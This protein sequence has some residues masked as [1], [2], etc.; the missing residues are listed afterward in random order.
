MSERQRAAVRPA[1]KQ[2]TEKG[3][4]QGEGQNEK[5]DCVGHTP[6]GRVF[7]QETIWKARQWSKATHV[8]CVRVSRHRAIRFVHKVNIR[9]AVGGEQRLL[10][11]LLRVVVN[12]RSCLVHNE[13]R[14]VTLVV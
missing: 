12:G 6:R 3:K 4:Q 5:N 10:I 2:T 14:Q 13:V 8:T 11:L 1:R 9:V 7:F